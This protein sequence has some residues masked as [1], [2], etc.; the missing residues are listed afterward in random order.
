MPAVSY[1]IRG[2]VIDLSPDNENLTK[3]FTKKHDDREDDP[4]KVGGSSTKKRKRVQKLVSKM[5]MNDDE[6]MGE[7]LL[8]L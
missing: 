4:N 1:P 3:T 8:N 2:F 6:E 5:Y 7:K